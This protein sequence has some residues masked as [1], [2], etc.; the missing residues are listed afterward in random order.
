MTHQPYS[1]FRTRQIK[2]RPFQIIKIGLTRPREELYARINGRVDQMIRD[3]LTEEAGK[4]Y[5]F[6]SYNSLNTVGYKELF[7]YLDGVWPLETAIEKIKRNTRVYTRKQMTWFKR[8]KEIH[9]FHPDE[10]EAILD[11]V[12]E[13][14]D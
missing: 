10:K 6:R 12:R 5:P 11:T 9:W 4:V 14:T 1:A 7:L 3:G 8:D 13:I 2:K